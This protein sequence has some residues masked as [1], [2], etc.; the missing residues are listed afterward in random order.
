VHVGFC[1]LDSRSCWQSGSGLGTSLR[2]GGGHLQTRTVWFDSGNRLALPLTH[3]FGHGGP[4]G[5][6]FG[7]QIL[8][9]TQRV[10]LIEGKS[11]TLA[12]VGK[13]LVSVV[14]RWVLPWI[15]CSEG[16]AEDFLV[17]DGLVASRISRLEQLTQLHHCHDSTLAFD[18]FSSGP[19]TPSMA[20]PSHSSFQC[21]SESDLWTDR[22]AL[23]SSV[24]KHLYP[25]R[26]HSL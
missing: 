6:H 12:R 11:H 21:Q 24:E 20:A 22:Q 10:D 5:V 7:S 13:N 9:L 18:V 2:I 15:R 8:S 4:P 26:V 19:A 1:L 25:S 16:F 14:D 3:C 23:L 17:R